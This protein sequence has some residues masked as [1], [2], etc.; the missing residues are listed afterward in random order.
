MKVTKELIESMIREQIKEAQ[1]LASKAA[2]T[3]VATMN[4]P[5]AAGVFKK[6]KDIVNSQGKPGQTGRKEEVAL[7][8][9]ALGI[10]AADLTMILSTLRGEESAEA[11]M[12]QN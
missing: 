2:P 9:G 11:P 1:N 5:A 10:T 7:I 3:A 6:L 4:L 8:L 12:E